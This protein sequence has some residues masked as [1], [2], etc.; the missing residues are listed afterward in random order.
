M[1]MTTKSVIEVQR[2]YKRQY[3]GEAPET[4]AIRD[5][6]NSV[7]KLVDFENNIAR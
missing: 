4:K 5:W 1:I 3:G 7:R 6:L 2:N